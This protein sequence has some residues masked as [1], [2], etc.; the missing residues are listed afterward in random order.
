MNQNSVETVHVTSA[1]SL[2]YSR[3]RRRANYLQ[4]SLF[5]AS[6][7]NPCQQLTVC[8]IY[9]LVFN[10]IRLFLQLYK[11]IMTSVGRLGLLLAT[12]CPPSCSTGSRDLTWCQESCIISSNL[13]FRQKRCLN[14]QRCLILENS[15]LND[16]FS[17]QDTVDT[18]VN[19]FFFI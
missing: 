19:K 15:S 10:L 12:C 8:T 5:Y 18:S 17:W 9:L 13:Q 11:L 14:S 3:A 4:L 16:I 1:L 2:D 6:P 7:G